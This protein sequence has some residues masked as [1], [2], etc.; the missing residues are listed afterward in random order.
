[1]KNT[2]VQ[3]LTTGDKILSYAGLLLDPKLLK[4]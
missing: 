3:N 4:G 2:M 1:M